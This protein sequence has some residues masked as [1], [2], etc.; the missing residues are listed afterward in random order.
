MSRQKLYEK[1]RSVIIGVKVTPDM[2][3]K[4][5]QCAVERGLTMSTL[6]NRLLEVYFRLEVG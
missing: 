5:K 4:L 1:K 3:A 2:R 6:I